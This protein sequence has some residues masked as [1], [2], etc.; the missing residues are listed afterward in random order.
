MNDVAI[1]LS[2]AAF[3]EGF[4]ALQ[5][6]AYLSICDKAILHDRVRDAVD[7][8]LTGMAGGNATR[9]GHETHVTAAR[10]AFAAMIG[11][12]ADEIAFGRNVS[13]GINAVVCAMDWKAG[14]N[15]VVCL[16]L[17]HPNNIYPWLRLKKR[18]VTLR[19][20]PPV[21]GRIDQAAMADA[22]DASTRMVSCASVSFAPGYRADLARLGAAARRHDALFLVDGVQSAGILCHDVEAENVDA[23]ATSTSKGLLGI[24]GAGFLYV[25]SRW[26]DRLE[27][28]YLSRPA[29]A[30]ENDDAS[31]I[32]AYDYRLQ[33]GARRFEVGSYNLA[34]AYAVDAAMA[35]LAGV[36]A[37]TVERQALMVAEGLRAALHAAGATPVSQPADAHETSHIVTAGPLDAGGHGFSS[38]AW[39]EPL[40]ARLAEA[41]VIHTVRRGQLRLATHGYNTEA[42]VALV[43]D[44]LAGWQRAA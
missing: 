38:T 3:R 15:A 10:K 44:A 1:P 4:P 42:D 35:L 17:E 28:A 13:D 31:A 18:G 30:A 41:G 37:D 5:S 11:A 27:P 24:Y 22:M 32:G 33:P 9:V 19:D 14:D 25:S 2:L 29:V 8:F 23:F 36:G 34:G 16:A 7:D 40:S 6:G 12:S 43:R 20:V 21:N 26:V 39:V